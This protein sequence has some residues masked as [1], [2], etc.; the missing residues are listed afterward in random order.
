MTVFTL[1]RKQQ[2]WLAIGLALGLTAVL[3]HIGAPLPT[4]AAPA[5]ILSFEF[6]GSVPKAQAMIASWNARA[7]VHAGLSL[8]LDFLYPLVYAAAI[9][10]ACLAAAPHL[11][12]VGPALAQ[13]LSRAIWLAAALDYVENIALIQLLLG[14]T[15][16]IWP[17]LAWIC[18]AIK[19][20]IVLAGISLALWGGILAVIRR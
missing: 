6:A 4:D 13:G 20:A 11:P 12:G 19:F 5:G 9:S 8:G 15:Q 14:S 18:A 7:Q 17:P 1:N 16:A 2:M 10:L 3:Q